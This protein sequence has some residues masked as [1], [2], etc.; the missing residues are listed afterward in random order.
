MIVEA[1]VPTH[2]IS[3]TS[4]F[5]PT[6]CSEEYKVHGN[7]ALQSINIQQNYVNHKTKTFSENFWRT[8]KRWV[9]YHNYFVLKDFC[10]YLNFYLYLLGCQHLQSSSS[11]ESEKND[12][13]PI[14]YKI[15]L[16]FTYSFVDAPYVFSTC[17]D[18]I[19]RPAET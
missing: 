4:S 3:C 8:I 15:I 13:F 6:L 19:L 16:N 14:Q 2:F 18:A 17:F 12:L 1:R 9:L 5:F 7:M 11:K 10:Q